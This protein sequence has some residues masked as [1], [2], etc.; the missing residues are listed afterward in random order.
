MN[1]ENKSFYVKD[2]QDF[3]FHSFKLHMIDTIDYKSII[4]Q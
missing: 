3:S 2:F 1:I 4:N